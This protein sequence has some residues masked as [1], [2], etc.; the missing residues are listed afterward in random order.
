MASSSQTSGLPPRKKTAW[1][2]TH[3]KGKAWFDKMGGPVNKLTTKLGAES[4]WPAPLDL[5][6]DKAARILRTFCIDGFRS[7]QGGGKN[8]TDKKHRSLDVIPPEVG[9]RIHLL[10]T[11]S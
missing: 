3:A 8:G 7:E 6:A 4:F 1:D 9:E 5:E 11:R 2:K 10:I